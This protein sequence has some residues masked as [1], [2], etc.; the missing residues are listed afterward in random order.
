[1]TTRVALFAEL[2]VSSIGNDA[3]AAQVIRLLEAGPGDVEV[4]VVSR[5]PAGARRALG[6]PATS[7]RARWSYSGPGHASGAAKG[8][9]L[10]LDLVHLVRLAGRFDAVVVPGTGA[11]EAGQGGPPRGT[12]LSLLLVGVAARC[13]ATP[14][15]WLGVG[16]SRY[17]RRLTR[18]VVRAAAATADVRSYRDPLTRESV[19]STGVDT[20]RD[21]L[22]G[23]VVTAR[24]DVPIPAPE[25][26]RGVVVVSVIDVPSAVGAAWATDTERERYRREIGR[27]V[28]TLV[29]R[30]E[31]VRVVVSDAADVAVAR[32]VVGD[33]AGG[34]APGSVEIRTPRD[35][36]ELLRELAGVRA[37]IGSR[38]HILVGAALDRVPFVTVVHADKV[39]VL[40]EDA[41]VGAYRVDA[42]S[43]GADELVEAFDAL[44]GKRD[45]LSRDVDAWALRA[46]D[47]TLRGYDEVMSRIRALREAS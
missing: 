34:R 21:V 19:A 14:Y 12:L 1:M 35:F 40:A 6:R 22:M 4:T 17:S 30:G 2:G 38:F 45:A 28:A 5:E 33:V 3:S 25:E 31:R 32:Q 7:A 41:G 15:G 44:T 10:A 13:R 23:D 42:H 36:D 26:N 20:A 16:G 46:R 37:V 8:V 11:L 43:F 27:V 29:G 39:R 18:W 9:R 24:S 47:R